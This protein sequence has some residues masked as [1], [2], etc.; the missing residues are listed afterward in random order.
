MK[1]RKVFAEKKDKKLYSIESGATI[2][3]A[4]KKITGIKTGY[5][6]VVKNGDEPI[7]FL[8]ILTK[9]DLLRA[10]APDGA[11]ADRILVDQF[12]TKNMIVANAE[13]DVQY[14]TNVML[15]HN[16]SYLPLID[17]K[18]IIGVLTHE[19]I[20]ESLNVEQDIEL[21]WL[22]DYNGIDFKNRVY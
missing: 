8:G 15:R 22:S 16:V 12:M 5:L 9:S 14:I 4:A 11:D 19:D 2:R 10:V 21:H 6:M 1:L 7:R 20:L 18:N 13:D 3:E 17:G